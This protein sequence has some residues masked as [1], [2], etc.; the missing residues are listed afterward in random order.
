MDII[1]FSSSTLSDRNLE[2]GGRA[3]EKRGII[4][5]GERW[6]LKFP[7]STLGMSRVS[8]LSYV[9]SP[10]SEYIGS[11]IYRILGYDT[12]ETLLGVCFDGKRKK[13]VCACKDFI[14][15]DKNEVLIPYTALRNDTNPD[16][17][18][19]HDSSISAPSNIDEII[20][21]LD[22]NDIL[23]KIEGAKE[24]FFDVVII[25]MLINNSDRN[26]D[27]WGVIKFKDT[28]TYKLAPVY[29]CGNCFYGKASEAKIAVFLS[30]EKRIRS[31]ALNGVT[32]YELEPE[33]RIPN[34]KILNIKNPNMKK[35]IIRVYEKVAE[36]IDEIE[37]LINSLPTD[38]NGLSV[39]S[40]ERKKY[41]FITFKL[42]FEEI[43]KP[44]YTILTAK[45]KTRS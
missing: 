29:D 7:K 39:M 38:F 26:E 9:T 18:E 45:S 34:V 8:D 15:D 5:K 20:F 36:K 35:A 3:G 25:D 12:H 4:Y 13:L 22:H 41:Y 24:R 37:S 21:Q 2:Y 42:R 16:I 14:A 40:D 32:A 30:D 1:D 6:F 27:N 17:M 23:S 33:V 19:K 31:S 11:Q 43:L 10:L 28:G 44:K